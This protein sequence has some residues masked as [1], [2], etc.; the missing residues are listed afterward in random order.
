MTGKASQGIT[1]VT[2]HVSQGLFCDAQR[3][4]TTILREIR[5]PGELNRTDDESTL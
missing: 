2:K 1:W 5:T 4:L 3:I